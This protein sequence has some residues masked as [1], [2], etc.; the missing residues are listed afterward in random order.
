MNEGTFDGVE[1][2]ITTGGGFLFACWSMYLGVSHLIKEYVEYRLTQHHSEI[3]AYNLIAD[4]LTVR[5]ISADEIFV[6]DHSGPKVIL[7]KHGVHVNP[8][9]VDDDSNLAWATGVGD[10]GV[11]VYNCEGKRGVSI[12]CTGNSHRVEVYNRGDK[13]EDK[14]AVITLESNTDFNRVGVS[15]FPPSN[16]MENSPNEAVMLV[17]EDGGNVFVRNKWNYLSMAI[18]EDGS[19]AISTWGKNGSTTT[20][21]RRES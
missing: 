21:A 15:G 13:E 2:F 6:G 11:H 9:V 19:G 1:N 8:P 18:D 20:I 17:K 3:D 16:L 7:N 12:S 5:K 10:T 4:S 14:E